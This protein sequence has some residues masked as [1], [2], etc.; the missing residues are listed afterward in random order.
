MVKAI[1]A[2]A[3]LLFTILSL[4]SVVCAKTLE[5]AKKVVSTPI[6]ISVAPDG[7]L[8]VYDAWGRTVHVYVYSNG[9]Y[10]YEQ[11]VYTATEKFPPNQISPGGYV[12]GLPDG[13]VAIAT[14][15]FNNY[16]VVILQ[17]Q[18][19]AYRVKEV[20]PMEYPAR[21]IAA[22]ECG[23]IYVA[24]SV[25]YV[26]GEITTSS[27]GWVY[28]ASWSPNSEPEK[29]VLWKQLTQDTPWQL[30]EALKA[31][32]NYG[33]MAMAGPTYGRVPWPSGGFVS[34]DGTYLVAD[35]Y[36]G[37]VLE[38]R[39]KE[40]AGEHT[41]FVLPVDVTRFGEYLVVLDFRGIHLIDD[42][43]HLIVDGS[44]LDLKWPTAIDVDRNGL[45]VIADF[46]NHK[47]KLVSFEEA[48]E[49]AR[50]IST[51]EKN[52]VWPGMLD[53][54]YLFGNLLPDFWHR[55]Y[56]AVCPEPDTFASLRN[57]HS[58]QN[59]DTKVEVIYDD[60]LAS[61][62]ALFAVEEGVERLL[63][64]T[65]FDKWS[66]KQVKV[67]EDDSG[68]HILFS[69]F[70]SKPK[71]GEN[72][73]GDESFIHVFLSDNRRFPE[74]SFCLDIQSVA[75]PEIHRLE[76]DA[77]RKFEFTEPYSL[78]RTY[79]PKSS[80]I[81]EGGFLLPLPHENA[82]VT[83][84]QNLPDLPY[85]VPWW[86]GAWAP[87]IRM[88]ST[89]MPC[90]GLWA[91]SSGVL[92]AYDS[93]E[94]RGIDYS[95]YDLALWAEAGNPEESSFSI[96][97][98]GAYSDPK[99]TKVHP[100]VSGERTRSGV[101]VCLSSSF[102]LV[103]WTDIK[104]GRTPNEVIVK[105]LV[106]SY[107]DYLTIGSSGIDVGWLP[108]LTEKTSSETLWLLEHEFGDGDYNPLL[109]EDLR[110]PNA[111]NLRLDTLVL[112]ASKPH[113]VV[114]QAFSYMSR[115]HM[116]TVETFYVNGEMC[117]AWTVRQHPDEPESATRHSGQDNWVRG[118]WLLY[119]YIF[120][121][122][123]EIL[124]VLDGLVRWAKH[125]NYD[126]GGIHMDPASHF[127]FKAGVGAEFLLTYYHTFKN[128]PERGDLADEALQ[129]ARMAVYS[130]LFIYL[131]DPDPYDR[132]SP[133]GMIQP[134][135]TPNWFGTVSLAETGFVWPSVIQVYVE[136]GDPILEYLINLHWNKAYIG[137]TDRLDTTAIENL[138]G[139]AANR[140][141]GA[142]GGVWDGTYGPLAGRV[143]AQPVGS[144]IVRVVMG[145]SSA[146]AFGIGTRSAVVTEYGF[147]EPGNFAVR[148]EV[149]DYDKNQVFD[150]IFTAPQ[151]SLAGLPVRINGK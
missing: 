133:Q 93:A 1:P 117:A 68:Q 47:V 80:I 71:G 123:E 42:D 32:L 44:I 46:G 66:A 91:P 35:K 97:Y 74:I 36:Q 136:T 129:L 141:W 49:L 67:W 53:S 28:K 10:E 151:R 126:F 146:I 51:Q 87:A 88:N 30:I 92:V 122:N 14:R 110:Q 84:K 22:N 9:E 12:A 128:D 95:G 147:S 72:V 70:C 50:H 16:K 150:G 59:Q 31:E 86:W 140:Y 58:I 98:P 94:A 106:E 100:T 79:V 55:E 2:F 85:P 48:L 142:K 15:E 62:F 69:D 127:V 145:Q 149:G 83:S 5:S 75:E 26:H 33:D 64:T 124:P 89:P 73:L 99:D 104:E 6:D 23:D 8:Y 43:N 24:V 125:M 18:D 115:Q 114:T 116:R 139:G 4:S 45:L 118:F 20:W 107:G 41:G 90:Y 120:N 105:Y 96:I 130:G 135:N 144:A 82:Y 52:W 25:E 113:S 103:Y 11:V 134:I 17:L 57:Q 112:A 138:W 7:R 143:Y 76:V 27:T 121:G 37:R 148:L 19:G 54:K 108:P 111:A 109:S 102:K 101:P 34:E 137:L 40:I 56:E 132:R 21:G 38:L 78:F 39:E 13:A 3:I 131:D 81:Y 65:Y 29:P 60:S 61:G 63:G 77:T 119:D